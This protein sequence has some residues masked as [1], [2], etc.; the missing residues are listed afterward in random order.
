MSITKLNETALQSWVDRL[1]GQH[2]V[3]GVKAKGDRFAFGPLDD[4]AELRLDYDVTIL[5]PKKYFLPQSQELLKFS[6]RGAYQPVGEPAPFVLFGVHPY[7]VV[8]IAQMDEVFSKDNHDRHYMQR[9]EK[10]VIVACDVQK[11]SPNVFAACMGTATVQEGF[12]VLLTRIGDDYLADAR[13]PKGEALLQRIEGGADPD[14]ASLARREQLWQDLNRF[15]MRHELKCAPAKLPG[16]LDQ[17]EE[18][19]IWKKR[20][21]RC[22]SCGSCNLVCPTCY[23]FDVQ[24]EVDWDLENG[25][26]V[27]RWD[28]C[29][30]AEFALVAGGHNFRATRAARYRHRY[31]RKGKYLWDRMGQIACVGCGRCV[32]ACTADIANPVEVFN[33][34][35]EDR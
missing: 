34:L 22:Y 23:C 11:A 12:D 32:T 25:R 17:Q 7:D 21:E 5:P 15:L 13:T 29:M 18:H 8:A 6:R 3:Y 9:R 4:A 27:R 20:A 16:V 33:T 10:A 28:G 1:I 19:P 35:L 14:P 2:Q 26:R 31:Y 24:D 30:L